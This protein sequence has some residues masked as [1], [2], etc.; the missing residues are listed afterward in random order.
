MESIATEQVK[1]Y[2][3]CTVNKESISTIPAIE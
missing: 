2:A 1:I 3:N